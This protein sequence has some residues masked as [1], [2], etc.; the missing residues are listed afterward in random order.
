LSVSGFRGRRVLVACL[1]AIG[2]AVALTGLTLLGFRSLVGAWTRH[3]LADAL[4]ILLLEGYLGMLI[5]LLAVLGPRGIRD[6][7]AFRYTSLTHVILALVAWL[8]GSTTAVAVTA[9]LVPLMGQPQSNAE[10]AL[11][12]GSDPFFLAVMVLTVC[13]VGPL[14][15][16]LLFRG[17]LLGWLLG[18]C[19]GPVAVGIS[20]ALFAGVHLIPTLLPFLFVL[21]VAAGLVR[22][23]TGSTF[24]SLVV[25]VCQNTL[26]VALVLTQLR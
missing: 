14:A 8:V 24:N 21:G 7:L 5:G 17:A 4:A 12:L 15:E 11:S 22:W 18:W 9:L 23:L 16:E 2:M 26:A 25:H 3:H 19:P 1:V 6:Q 20:A 10:Q 13:L